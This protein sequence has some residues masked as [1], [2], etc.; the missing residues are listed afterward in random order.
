MNVSELRNSLNII[1]EESSTAAMLEDWITRNN[2]STESE[3]ILY[4]LIK[5]LED[6]DP[7]LRAKVIQFINLSMGMDESINEDTDERLVQTFGADAGEIAN[8]IMWRLRDSKIGIVRKVGLDRFMDAVDSVAEFHTG[9]EDLGSSDI[10]IM[11]KQV[12]ENLGIKN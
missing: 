10:S 8:A 5:H 12:L 7:D 2:A 9:V 4:A 6:T 1:S 11:V 3:Q